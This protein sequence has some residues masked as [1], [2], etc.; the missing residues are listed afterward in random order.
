MPALD[1][2]FDVIAQVSGAL[3]TAGHIAAAAAM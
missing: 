1:A 2:C 3:L